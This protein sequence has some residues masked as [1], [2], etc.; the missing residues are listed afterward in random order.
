M[1]SESACKAQT[2]ESDCLALLP[3]NGT[4][5]ETC[6]CSIF[7]CGWVND[8]ASCSVLIACPLSSCSPIASYGRHWLAYL[9]LAIVLAVLV[10]VAAVVLCRRRA[11]QRARIAREAIAGA[12]QA[13]EVPKE[14]KVAQVAELHL[15]TVSIPE[16]MDIEAPLLNDEYIKV[17]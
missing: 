12:V 11:A 5:P 7:G 15:D 2:T 14:H 3:A 9:I 1:A 6:H 10:L 8:S 4:V 16:S 13:Q 17:D